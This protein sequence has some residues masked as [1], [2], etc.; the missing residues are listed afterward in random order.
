[1]TKDNEL[2]ARSSSR[3]TGPPTTSLR[4]SL[5]TCAVLYL[6][7][8]LTPIQRRNYRGDMEDMAQSQLQ[9]APTVTKRTTTRAGWIGKGAN[10]LRGVGSE[11]QL[12]SAQVSETQIQQSLVHAALGPSIHGKWGKARLRFLLKLS[13]A[14]QS[15]RLGS[16]WTPSKE[17]PCRAHSYAS[18]AGKAVCQSANAACSLLMHPSGFL[19]A[20]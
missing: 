18:L 3:S 8:Q 13:K 16:G 19:S 7:F 2:A 14:A 4:A 20:A 11:L 10:A 1:M 12:T 6:H 5:L 15:L 17:Q 9:R